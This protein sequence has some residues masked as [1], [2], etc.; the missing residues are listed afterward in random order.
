MVILERVEEMSRSAVLVTSILLNGPFQLP[1][2]REDQDRMEVM[3]P[4]ARM[5]KTQW[6]R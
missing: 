4:T 3:E 2:D 6:P 5:E 1:E